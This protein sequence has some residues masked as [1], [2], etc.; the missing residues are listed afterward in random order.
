MSC[1]NKLDTA[2]KETKRFSNPQALSSALTALGTLQ[3]RAFGLLNR[4][5]TSVLLLYSEGVRCIEQASGTADSSQLYNISTKH[6]YLLQ[7]IRQYKMY[8][9]YPELRNYFRA[10][11]ICGFSYQSNSAEISIEIF[12]SNSEDFSLYQNIIKSAILF[13]VDN[14]NGQTKIDN[15]A[16]AKQ[17]RQNTTPLLD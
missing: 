17:Y 14:N 9:E 13:R 4:L 6:N 3:P 12:L 5:V 2:T 8:D 1:L 11:Y 7:S 16:L 10:V 15:N